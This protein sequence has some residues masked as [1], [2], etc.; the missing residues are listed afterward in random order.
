MGSQGAC[1]CNDVFGKQVETKVVTPR[2]VRTVSRELAREWKMLSNCAEPQGLTIS[3]AHALIELEEGG[4]MS[5]QAVAE[6]LLVDKS[7]ASRALQ[8]LA[9]QGFVQFEQSKTDG[10]AKIAQLT[11]AGRLRLAQLHDHVDAQVTD[12]LSLLG[13]DEQ[14]QV[15]DGLATY[16]KALRYSRLQQGFILRPATQQDNEAIAGIIRA[17][18]QEYGLTAEAGY[19]VGDASVD[20]MYAAYDHDGAQYW[21]VEHQGRVVGGGGIAPLAGGDGTIGELQKMYFL[22]ECRG[23]GLGRRIVL[24]AMEYARSYGYSTCYLET[25]AILKEAI[26][27]Y[28]KIGFTR[29]EKPMGD[30]GHCVC[31]A[32]YV[33]PLTQDSADMAVCDSSR[34]VQQAHAV[35][36]GCCSR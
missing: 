27:L 36:S 23:R 9:G 26:A 29:L 5:V 1:G 32:C 3:E 12:G 7:N 30:T 13:K 2:G 19:A 18:S 11:A 33:Y 6:L 4:S 10:R 16:A 8:S 34:T 20:N 14:Q 31:E 24:T 22:P 28:E 21:V 35:G 17:V 25:T 15:Y